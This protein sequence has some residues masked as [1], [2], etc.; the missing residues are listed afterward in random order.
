MKQRALFALLVVFAL[1]VLPGMALAGL[2]NYWEPIIYVNG[3]EVDI[4]VGTANPDKLI[5]LAVYTPPGATV[6][7][8]QAS[9]DLDGDGDKDVVLI[10]LTGNAGEIRVSNRGNGPG[11]MIDI[12]SD[13]NFEAVGFGDIRAPFSD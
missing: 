12:G 3:V 8:D 13:G 1:L 4:W 11:L 2:N 9:L 10:Q 6:E 7:V 5:R